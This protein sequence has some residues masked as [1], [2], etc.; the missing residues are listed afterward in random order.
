MTRWLWTA[1]AVVIAAVAARKI[2][3][4]RESGQS[5]PRLKQKK[6]ND[7]LP[8]AEVAEAVIQGLK[9]ESFLILPHE[10]VAQYYLNKAQNYDRWIGGM[11]KLRQSMPPPTLP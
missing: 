9:E 2:K 7:D 11:R 8:V 3:K 10:Q 4:Q 6:K 5:N 1:A